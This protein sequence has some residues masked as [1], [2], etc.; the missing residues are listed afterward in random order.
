MAQVLSFH[1]KVN[2]KEGKEVGGGTPLHAA[3]SAGNMRMVSEL[4]KVGA[5]PSIVDAYGSTPL[6]I[7]AK[8]GYAQI[9]T[10]LVN[11]CRRH[12]ILGP[13]LEPFDEMVDRG[14]KAAHY[15]AREFGHE[16]MCE[17]LPPRPYD[18]LE[19]FEAAIKDKDNRVWTQE[20]KKKKGKKGKKGGKGGKGKKKK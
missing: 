18:P 19:H 6:H 16:E 1:P 13:N 7:C 20:K 11:H 9:A 14:G 2:V 4:L 5:D 10:E 3:A 15:W 17:T 12:K 8:K